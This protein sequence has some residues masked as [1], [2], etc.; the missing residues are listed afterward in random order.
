MVCPLSFTTMSIDASPS[1]HHP[2]INKFLGVVV[3]Q[4][5]IEINFKVCLSGLI[6]IDKHFPFP[7]CGLVSMVAEEMNSIKCDRLRFGLP[8]R[9]IAYRE[10]GAGCAIISGP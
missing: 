2:C 7:E 10:I 6:S 9:V 4:G 1:T 5:A 3:R 8:L